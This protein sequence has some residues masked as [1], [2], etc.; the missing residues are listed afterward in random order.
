M[1]E[2]KSTLDLVLERTRH[3][4]LSEEEKALARAQEWEAKV[5]GHLL[6]LKE[7]RLRAEELPGLLTQAGDQA[8]DFKAALRKALVE[9]LDLTG[10]NLPLLAGLASLIGPDI[11]GLLAEIETLLA[12]HKAASRTLT[13]RAREKALKDLADLGLSGSAL[14]PKIERDQG[15]VEALARL[16]QAYA[17]RLAEIKERLLA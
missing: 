17:D 11:K 10:D 15:Y 12:D 16:K 8:E 13:V 5:K 1:A 2:I 7:G 9:T 6:A 3:L 4:S 14:K